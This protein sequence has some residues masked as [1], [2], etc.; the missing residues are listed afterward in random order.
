M[1]VLFRMLFVSWGMR[2]RNWIVIIVS[3]SRNFTLIVMICSS[4]TGGGG[5]LS[6]SYDIVLFL[7]LVKC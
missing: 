6:M 4:W 1:T 3:R 2:T 5:L 7:I